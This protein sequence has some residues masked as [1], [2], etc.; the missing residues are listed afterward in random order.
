MKQKRRAR[1]FLGQ[2]RDSFDS[3][4]AP[5]WATRAR[6]ELA[7]V[8]GRPPSPDGLTPTEAEV[9]QLVAQGL[10]NREV[11]HA[12][13]IS[14]HTVDAN[15]RRIYRKLQVRSRTELARRL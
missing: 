8:G 5:L 10:T 13:F 2:A 4:G 12:L 14:P 11:A 7:R 6:A 15:L 3:L 9:A 1:E